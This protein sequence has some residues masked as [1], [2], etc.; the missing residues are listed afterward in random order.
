MDEARFA[1]LL[2]QQKRTLDA[3]KGRKGQRATNKA[4]RLQLLSIFT[5]GVSRPANLEKHF[6]NR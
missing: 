5:P 3:A 2:E 1:Q 6:T 4:S